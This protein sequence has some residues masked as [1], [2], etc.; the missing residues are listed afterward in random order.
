MPSRRP[1]ATVPPEHRPVPETTLRHF[2]V[3]FFAV[4]MGL[5]GLAL[6]WLRAHAV[7]GAPVLVGQI[8]ILAAAAVYLAAAVAYARKRAAHPAEVRAE[9]AHPVRMPFAST[10][11]I[12]ALLV[13]TGL[14]DLAPGFARVVWWIGAA[15][16]I[17]VT[18]LVLRRW[19][20]TSD[21]TLAHV[22]PAWF[23][24]VVGNLVVPLAG[25]R[26]GEAGLSQFFWSF[27]VIFWLGL[28]PV[29]L[30]RLFV[31]EASLPPKLQPTTAI[32]VAPPA[33]AYLS[34]V[35]L[36]EAAAGGLLGRVLFDGA[37]FFALFVLSRFDV[38]RTAP[39]AVSWW[40][41]SFPA[42]ALSTAV[43]VRVGQLADA[44]PLARLLAWILL[45][46]VTVLIGGL[47][48]RTLLAMASRHL[49]VAE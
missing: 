15:G 36:D 32:L 13:A 5:A 35:R 34:L 42:A 6:A 16:Q 18:L 8:L 21:A 31:H 11:T 48:V 3:S 43:T 22:T 38:L 41:Y 12:A 44:D 49:F 33:V 46:L 45:G 29:V 37:L 4:V 2:P 40:A 7:L 14:V 19:S 17:V 24:P 20:N 39:F 10:V 25:V 30:T 27:G 26:L 47:I 9:L 28:L 1:S 23:I